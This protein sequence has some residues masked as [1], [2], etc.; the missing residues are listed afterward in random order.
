VGVLGSP[1]L[2]YGLVA[3]LMLVNLMQGVYHRHQGD[4]GMPAHGPS[5]LSAI[6]RARPDAWHYH[7]LLLG[8]EVDFLSANS[9]TCPFGPDRSPHEEAYS[10]IGGL[11]DGGADHD[12]G[13]D[14]Q[15]PHTGAVLSQP[16]APLPQGFGLPECPSAVPPNLTAPPPAEAAR[17]VR[18]GVQ[19][20]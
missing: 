16:P 6:H 13:T 3:W 15:A 9:D 12:R 4:E 7:L 18:S 2:C 10:F 11:L 20:V 5:L 19:Q 1:F 8:V 17:G 14:A